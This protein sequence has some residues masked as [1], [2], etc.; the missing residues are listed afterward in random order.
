MTHNYDK[1]Y[2]II[3][4][5]NTLI[6]KNHEIVGIEAIPRTYKLLLP[7]E[8]TKI[9]FFTITFIKILSYFENDE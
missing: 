8:N 5:K 1:I 7:S 2:T 4:S 9:K 3:K 6:I